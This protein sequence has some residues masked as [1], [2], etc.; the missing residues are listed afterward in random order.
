MAAE[1]AEKVGTAYLQSKSE[2]V[3]VYEIQLTA[4]SNLPEKLEGVKAQVN[5]RVEF[6]IGEIT[7]PIAK[8]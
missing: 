4:S 8:E 7:I 6:A 2:R 5:E 3:G 1:P